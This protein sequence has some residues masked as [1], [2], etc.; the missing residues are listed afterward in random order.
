MIPLHGNAKWV[1]LNNDF[2]TWQWKRMILILAVTDD[3]ADDMAD[4]GSV[5]LQGK[6]HLCINFWE[7]RGLCPNFHIHV[8]V[9]DLYIPKPN[10]INLSRYIS[11]GIGRQNIIMLFGK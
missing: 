9:S 6:S 7:L 3:M 1:L 8:S 2:S 4:D 10:Y 11:V 5:T